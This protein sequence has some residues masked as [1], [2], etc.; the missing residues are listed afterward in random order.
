M[1][2]YK[3]L[4]DSKIQFTTKIEKA[5][6][7]NAQK[8]VIES[9]KDEVSIKGF[10]KGQAPDEMVLGAIGPQRVAEEALN[11]ALDKAFW[12]FVQGEEIRIVNRPDIEMPDKEGWPMEVKFTVEVYPTI[13]LGDYK[14]IK[15]KPAKV[16][17][18]EDEIDEVLQTLCA[19]AQI[20]H[21]VDRAAKDRDLL[22]VDFVAKDKKGETIP[23]T[24]GKGQIFRIG[25]GHFLPDLEKAFLGMK[26]GDTKDKVKVK[27]PKDYQA[28]DM[29]GKTILFNIALHEVKA[30][31]PEKLTEDQIEQFAG[32]PMK[33]PAFREQIRETI[34]TNKS[35]EAEQNAIREY[36][37]ALLKLV[38]ADLPPSWIDEE[39]K[40][41]FMRMTQNPQFQANPA[42]FWAQI[43]K[44]EEA[45]KKDIAEEAQKSLKVFLGLSQVIETEGIELDKDEMNEV[46]QLIEAQ[47]ARDPNTN[48]ELL[49]DKIVLNR[50]IDKHLRAQVLSA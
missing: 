50:K 20:G 46:D 11:R 12:N 40:N 49:K 32:K 27:F 6:L 16:E 23:R 37:E 22:T 25:M 41:R 26:A 38:N 1:A 7:E 3:Q 44:S 45:F 31:E 28:P 18:K 4:A 42:A 36:E 43:G 10:R 24:E 47:V 34:T 9:L 15:V 33:L 29:A 8:A 14:K 35:K 39:V 13:K 21:T 17:I 5:A 2:N 48:Q 19:Q 30:I